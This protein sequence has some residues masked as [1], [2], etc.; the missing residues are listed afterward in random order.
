MVRS[1]LLRNSQIRA[2]DKFFIDAILML[3]GPEFRQLMTEE[4]E[5]ETGGR[6]NWG[7]CRV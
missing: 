6:A 7:V 2:F 1:M 4:L 3:A 5:R